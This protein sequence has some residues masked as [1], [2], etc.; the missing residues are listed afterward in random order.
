MS[1]DSEVG[2]LVWV[3][4]SNQRKVLHANYRIHSDG[5]VTMGAKETLHEFKSKS[6]DSVCMNNMDGLLAIAGDSRILLFSNNLSNSIAGTFSVQSGG[7]IRDVIPLSGDRVLTGLHDR[8]PQNGILL[9]QE[10]VISVY[11]VLE[12]EDKLDLVF[13]F[14]DAISRLEFLSVSLDTTRP[15]MIALSAEAFN[16]RVHLE[17]FDLSQLRPKSVSI[18]PLMRFDVSRLLNKRDS[19]DSMVRFISQLSQL[20][21]F[22]QSTMDEASGHSVCVL[23][24]S[25][26]RDQWFSFMPNFKVLNRNEPYLECEEEFDFNQDADI[27]T[28]RSTLNRYKKASRELF[29][30]LPNGETNAGKLDQCEDIVMAQDSKTTSVFPFLS[31][32]KVSPTEGTKMDDPSLEHFGSVF[33]TSQGPQLLSNS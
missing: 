31:P 7:K 23:W 15:W 13:Q 3:E 28:I 26:L 21:A 8:A 25:V 19:K 5:T 20:P 27:A 32:W 22:V 6:V 29:Q 4:K 1:I 9:V 33:F 17:L 2:E 16:N 10:D 24:E 11:R 30:F 18:V 14:R 12:D